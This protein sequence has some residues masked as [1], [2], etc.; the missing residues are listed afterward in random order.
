MRVINENIE[1][2][3]RTAMLIE[4]TGER[5]EGSPARWACLF[6]HEGAILCIPGDSEPSAVA[7]AV[8]F[9][10]QID[11]QLGLALAVLEIAHAGRELLGTRRPVAGGVSR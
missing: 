1:V 10:E 7:G 11:R 6:E 8:S 3:G 5:A 9:A 2:V 4:A